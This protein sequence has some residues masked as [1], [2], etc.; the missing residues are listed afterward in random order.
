MSVGREEYVKQIGEPVFAVKL[1]MWNN[2]NYPYWAVQ[3]RWETADHAVENLPKSGKVQIV[4]QHLKV[5]NLGR[6]TFTDGITVLDEEGVWHGE[7]DPRS[8]DPRWKEYL[9]LK[10]IFDE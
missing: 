9:R 1:Q 3:S 2:Q 7:Y 10:E 5:S 4:R 8:K 6:I